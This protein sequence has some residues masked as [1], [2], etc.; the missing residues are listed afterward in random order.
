MSA[1]TIAI[2]DIHGHLAALAA[3]IAAIELQPDDTLVLLGDYV[4]RGPDSKGVLEQVI[5]LSERFH[6][7]ALK[8]NH[9]EMMLGAREGR[10]NLRFWMGCGGDAALQSYGQAKD[11]SLIP[12]EHYRFLESLPLYHESESH[13]FS[14]SRP[15]RKP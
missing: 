6:V 13:F 11:V 1:R 3:I 10:D 9:E 2:G 4:D 8:G 7:V 15:A 5:Q 12:R 14:N